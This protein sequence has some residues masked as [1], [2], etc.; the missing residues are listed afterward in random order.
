MK[1]AIHVTH[2]AIQKVG[3]IG[4]V[5]HGLVTSKRYSKHFDKTLLYTP[6]FS[7]EAS[8]EERLGKD[9]QVLYSS[10]DSINKTEFGNALKLIEEKYGIK[11][12]Y[13][14]KR[15]FSKLDK[16]SFFETDIIAVDIWSMTPAFINNFKYALWENYK[17][18]SDRFANDSDYEQYLRI[19]VVLPE[20]A[21]VLYSNS[22]IVLFS[23][24]Y[25]GMASALAYE[26]QKKAG[27]RNNV[28]TIFY[29]HE[30]STARVVVETHE[31]HDFSF[32]NILNIDRPHHVS[33]EQEFGSYAGY[34]RNELVK[35]AIHLNYI[36]AVSDI[37]KDE[38]LYLNPEA[39]PDK[40]KVVYNGIP[41]E[42]INYKLKEDSIER[43]RSYCE[44]LYNF[45]P[46]YI[47]THVTRLILSKG[48]WRDIRILYSLDELFEKMN[49]K[50]FFIIL[51]TLIGTGRPSEE[52]YKM[53]DEYGWPVNHK[54]GWPD[55]VDSEMSLYGYMELFNARSKAIKGVFINQFGFNRSSC[56]KRI[57]DNTSVSD[58][59]L[60][61]DIEF[62][63]SVYEPFG[64]SQLETLPYGGIPV[65]ST[66]CGC[67]GLVHSSFKDV[68]VPVDFISVPSKYK[69]DFTSKQSFQNV[70]IEFRDKIETEICK[71]TAEQIIKI[72]PQNEKQRKKR[73]NKMQKKCSILD[74]E[75][76]FK[77]MSKYLDV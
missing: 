35:C 25:M 67:E 43:M 51:S 32:Y 40:I 26:I 15:Y 6:L 37:V 34:S 45:R 4:S 12:I 71:N 38:Y 28:M 31:G 3:G 46:D 1:T 18:E 70:S 48:M 66:S 2:E 72:L 29:A 68:Y 75:H 22:S 69:D 62:G 39:N 64:I 65:L 61:S 76:I 47:F 10:L 23:H 58:L 14:K 63:M 24:E 52:I 9:S 54:Q 36:F 44:T 16:S 60:S 8:P 21:D 5:I 19:G 74:W 20:I 33:L 53:E 73:F 41:F 57:P 11:I 17:I 77:K 49:I 27:T 56:G 50:G 7:R 30:V 59:R 42:K 55:L 13:G